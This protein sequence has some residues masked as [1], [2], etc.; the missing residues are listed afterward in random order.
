VEGA[1]PSAD[2]RKERDDE[3]KEKREIKSEEHK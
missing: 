1:M 3:R 2:V